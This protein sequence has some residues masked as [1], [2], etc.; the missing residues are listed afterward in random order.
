VKIKEIRMKNCVRNGLAGLV[1]GLSLLLV[2]SACNSP[3]PAQ[4]QATPVVLIVTQVVTQVSTATSA[5]TATTGPTST[6]EPSLTP[7]ATFD[8]YN[9]PAY[10]PLKDCVASR[11]HVGDTAIVG[12][13]GTTNG[14]RYGEDL[15]VDTVFDHAA[16]GTKLDIVAGPYCS[17]GWIVWQIRMPSGTVGYTPEGNG[18]EYWLLPTAP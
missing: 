4:T 6:P 16:Q 3:A 10:Y 7:K 18:N 1:T 13:G 8:P 14:I 15:S 5:P 2:L 12:P 9:V 17:G 11:L